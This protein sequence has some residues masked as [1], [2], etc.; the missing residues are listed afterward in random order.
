[1][2]CLP[3]AADGA[4]G[5]WGSVG[6]SGSVGAAATG[7]FGSSGTA[8][9]GGGG[10]VGTTGTG[11]T[12]GFVRPVVV[13]GLLTS[14]CTFFVLSSGLVEAINPGGGAGTTTAGWEKGAW[15]AGFSGSFA[16]GLVEAA[17]AAG[18]VLVL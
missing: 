11:G 14:A 1:L 2:F 9:A 16:G 15:A 13:L 8:G 7:N 10:G 4:A 5:S 12:N 17:G 3:L 6:N 18:A